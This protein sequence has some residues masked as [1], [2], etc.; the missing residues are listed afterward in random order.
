MTGLS[1][2]I[3]LSMIYSKNYKC[4]LSYTNRA[5]LG[6]HKL[7]LDIKWSYLATFA[8]LFGWFGYVTV[9]LG[10]AIAGGMF[11]RKANKIFKD[12]LNVFGMTNDILAVGYYNGGDKHDKV[13]NKVLKIRRKR[14]LN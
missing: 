11:Q 12:L 2:D 13:I 1:G 3:Q 6:Y 9:S 4:M 7:K 5:S 14:I 8:C 10:A